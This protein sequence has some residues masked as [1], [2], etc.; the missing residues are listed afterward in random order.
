MDSRVLRFARPA[1]AAAAAFRGGQVLVA[2]VLLDDSPV[3][4]GRI[5][6]QFE[7]WHYFSADGSSASLVSTVS[8]Q[9]L[10]TQIA[11]HYFGAEHGLELKSP[12]LP[13]AI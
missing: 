4:V 5:V 2:D 9:D 13:L 3:P 12:A 8:R 1:E 6:R 10:E 7:A 11:R